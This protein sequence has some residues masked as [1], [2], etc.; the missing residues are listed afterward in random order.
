M[1]SSA[2]NYVSKL[3]K[4]TPQHNCQMPQFRAGSMFLNIKSTFFLSLFSFWH[5]LDH[6]HFKY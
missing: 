5:P 1:G 6:D 4:I 3:E 2:L